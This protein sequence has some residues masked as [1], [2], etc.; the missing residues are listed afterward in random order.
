MISDQSSDFLTEI[1][2]LVG[3]GLVGI[4]C[5][6]F[7]LIASLFYGG[8]GVSGPFLDLIPRLPGKIAC[9]I[10]QVLGSI[11]R[12]INNALPL[13][14]GTVGS[15]PKPIRRIFCFIGNIIDATLDAVFHIGHVST[16]Y[17]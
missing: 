13:L 4:A 11:L 1:A 2:Y 12:P 17:N 8:T 15:I 5:P 6:V 10:H 7:D 3:R 9:T 14:L 16:L